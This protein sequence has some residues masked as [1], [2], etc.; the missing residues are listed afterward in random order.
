MIRHPLPEP[1]LVQRL[2]GLLVIELALLAVIVLAGCGKR[3]PTEPP[4][5]VEGPC[6]AVQ[7]F[8]VP[9]VG[10]AVATLHYAVCPPDSILA[11]K[12]WRRVP[13]WAERGAE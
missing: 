8:P 3:A 5:R 2:G 13:A 4:P 7:L 1:S 6:T 12:G 10:I 11:A 9:G